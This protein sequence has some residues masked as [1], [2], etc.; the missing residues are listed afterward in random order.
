M[1][2]LRT[3]P[4]FFGTLAILIVAGIGITLATIEYLSGKEP[5]RW[6]TLILKLPDLLFFM[7]YIML[8]SIIASFTVFLLT[9]IVRNCV[10]SIAESSIVFGSVIITA[11]IAWNEVNYLFGQAGR[12]LANMMQGSIA[13]MSNNVQRISYTHCDTNLEYCQ[14]RTILDNL[15]GPRRGIC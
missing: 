9:A 10:A 8:I 6:D 11:L 13:L 2:P 12:A 4:R 15:E 3:L 7:L 5:S 1:N 14:Q